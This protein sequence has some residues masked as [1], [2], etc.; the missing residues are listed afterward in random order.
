MSWVCRSTGRPMRTL[1]SF[2][3]SISRRSTVKPFSVITT[4]ARR[5]RTWAGASP[6]PGCPWPAPVTRV[7]PMAFPWMNGV[8]GWK[9][10]DRS[11]RPLLAEARPMAR[12][13]NTHC[14]NTWNG[15][16]NTRLRAPW[17]WIS[18]PTCRFWQ[19]A[20]SRSRSFGTRRFCPT[21]SNRAPRS[22][23]TAH[24]NGAWRLH[25]TVLTG[26]RA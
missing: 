5:P 1:P 13:P 8:S 12:Q 14:A 25:P 19:G 2:S 3:A 7:F 24:S 6:M 20:V 11:A 15:F 10:A 9:I 4:M 16:A 18:T 21:W 22:T 26:K 23:K 17:E